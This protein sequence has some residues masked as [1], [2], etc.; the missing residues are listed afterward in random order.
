MTILPHSRND[1][2]RWFHDWDFRTG[3]E[4]GVW[5]GHFSK[6]LCEA[7]RGLQ[8][9]CVD[10]WKTSDDYRDPK[11]DTTK[12]ER[13]YLEAQARLAPYN[14]TIRRATSLHAAKE[15]ADGSLDFVYIDG[16]HG[17]AHVAADLE[18]W[19]PKVRTGGVVSGHDYEFKKQRSPWIQVKQAV[20]AF[21]S[22][23]GIKDL[24]I[25]DADGSPS[26]FWRVQ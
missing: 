13:A 8:L 11:S 4:I 5:T 10:P 26:F 9:L 18:A 16:N 1:L 15:V 14:C 12:L 2:A 21:V 24:T 25:L 17:L 7:N 3:A 20:D 19:T 23:H 6:R 22:A